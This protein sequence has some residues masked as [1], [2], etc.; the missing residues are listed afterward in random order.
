[1][2][3][4]ERAA[5]GVERRQAALAMAE[6]ALQE[7][8][9]AAR[10]VESKQAALAAQETALKKRETAINEAEM[11]LRARKTEMERRIADTERRTSLLAQ[12]EKTVQQ[13]K[14]GLQKCG[15]AFAELVKHGLELGLYD[16]AALGKVKGE[17][18]NS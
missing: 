12:E 9:A 10:K 1:M 8:E 3:R 6:A 18:R 7:R 11:D 14:D 13:V 15:G 17:R 2:K 16:G 5:E 4:R